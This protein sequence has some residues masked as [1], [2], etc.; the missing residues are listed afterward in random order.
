MEFGYFVEPILGNPL[1]QSLHNSSCVVAA[2][3]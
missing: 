3:G 2:G 1:F